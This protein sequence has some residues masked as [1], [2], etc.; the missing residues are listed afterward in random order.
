MTDPIRIP[1]FYNCIEVTTDLARQIIALG[2]TE[3]TPVND[4]LTEAAN[5]PG[6]APESR[7][8]VDPNDAPD[9]Y[10]AVA[11]PEGDCKAC[12]F[13]GCDC[14]TEQNCLPKCRRDKCGVIFKRKPEPFLGE[15]HQSDLERAHGGGNGMDT[16]TQLENVLAKAPDGFPFSAC[17]NTYCGPRPASTAILAAIRAG[18][19]PGVCAS[20]EI[21]KLR[22]MIDNATGPGYR[23]NWD[24]LQAEI[25]KLRADLDAAMALLRDAHDEL[26]S[27]DDGKT[28]RRDFDLEARIYALLEKAKKP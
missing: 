11:S 5:P 13:N 15:A 3:P 16:L 21:A 4:L 28:G 26:D 14:E 24:A 27:W 22:A 8:V 18:K 20:D 17:N 25:A 1:V 9:G 12:A 19:I 7:N 10:I 2:Q 23:E 6:T